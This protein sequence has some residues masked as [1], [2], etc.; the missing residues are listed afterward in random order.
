MHPRRRQWSRDDLGSIALDVISE[1]GSG[2]RADREVERAAIAREREQR[3]ERRQQQAQRDLIAVGAGLLAGGLTASMGVI[4]VAAVGVG[5]LTGGIVGFGLRAAAQAP[6]RPTRPAERAPIAAPKVDAEGISNARADVVRK[7]IDEATADLRRLEI[8]AARLKDGEARTIAERLTATGQR[9]TT[10]VAAAP[11]KLGLAQRA[12]TYHLPKA[13]YLAETLGS[14][15]EAGAD[16]KRLLTARHV[17]ARME[18]L[19]EKTALDLAQVDAR[20]MDVELRLI[21][22]ALDEDLD[23][24]SRTPDR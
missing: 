9:L 22:Q 16:E 11:D 1:L 10:A 21:N 6:T 20:E 8:A 2:R 19:F 7:V 13:V 17:F 3:R 4:T 23:P 24:V 18:N 14:L 12:F 5:L 15:E